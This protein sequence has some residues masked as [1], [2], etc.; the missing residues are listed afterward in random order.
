MCSERSSLAVAVGEFD[1]LVLVI[2]LLDSSIKVFRSNV[3]LSYAEL[4]PLG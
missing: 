1:Y 3:K 4:D 2:A